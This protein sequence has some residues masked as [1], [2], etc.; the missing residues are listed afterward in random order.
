MA[1]GLISAIF[2]YPGIHFWRTVRADA[3]AEMYVP[4]RLD[5]IFNGVPGAFCIPDPFA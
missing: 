2:C 1:L 5:E 4:A 3:V